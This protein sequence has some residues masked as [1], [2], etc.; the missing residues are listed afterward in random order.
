VAPQKRLSA[1]V[2]SRPRQGP[3]LELDS[4][5]GAGLNRRRKL[6]V[7]MGSHERGGDYS[8]EWV[9]RGEAEK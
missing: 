8:C 3:R 9:V 5:M 4:R 7:R 6:L 2:A 1:E